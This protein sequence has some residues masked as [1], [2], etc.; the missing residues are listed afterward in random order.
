MTSAID[1]IG[2]WSVHGLC[3][4]GFHEMCRQYE[5]WNYKAF[6]VCACKSCDHPKPDESQIEQRKEAI[7]A[8]LSTDAT[9]R[10]DRV[11][12][13]DVVS[14][15]PSK[16]K[17]EPSDPAP[18]P[19][20]ADQHDTEQ[21]IMA[22]KKKAAKKATKKKAVGE[23]G[24]LERSVSKVVEQY[25]NGKVDLPEGKTL[26]PHLIAKQIADNGDRPEAPS[27]GAV[28]AVIQRWEKYGYALTHDKPFA[29][30]RVS[31]QG[32]KIGLDGCKQ[33]HREKAAA[34]RAKARE[35]AKEMASA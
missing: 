32:Q 31:A 7:R 18:E 19:P 15:A 35:E 25:E 21:A 20:D 22:E 30:K 26:T 11:V 33:K 3:K 12:S 2:V 4:S 29:F 17:S 14:P 10:I 34:E 16:I 9:R 13:R 5:D 24:A 6:H 28:A 8:L 27:T 1:Y 23:R